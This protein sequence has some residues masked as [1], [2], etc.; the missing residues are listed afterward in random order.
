MCILMLI[1]NRIKDYP[2]V[3]AA[4]RDE[5]YNRPT[6]GPQ[7]LG[8]H[9]KVWGGR[10]T[11]A[12]G[13]W[14]GV[15]EYGLAV[16]LT[17]RRQRHE[18]VNDPQK[19]SRGLICLDALQ[20]RTVAEAATFLLLSIPNHYN[21]FNMLI[22]DQTELRWIAYRDKPHIYSLKPGIHILANGNIND[23]NT[24]RIRRLQYLLKD[25]TNVTLQELLPFLEEICCD[26]ETN[27]QDHETIC[28]HRAQEN[29]GTVSS[30]ILALNSTNVSSTKVY[31]YAEGQPCITPYQDYSLL[32]T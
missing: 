2:I 28:M 23:F 17:N 19:R 13:T 22:A 29:Y 32:L 11:R 26:H 16:G 7:L 6:Q 8:E 15:N 20:Y 25:Y 10:D 14:L 12:N 27:V 4:N 1:Y 9:P 31:R 24:V 5:Y 18:Q 30:T 3:I 21:P